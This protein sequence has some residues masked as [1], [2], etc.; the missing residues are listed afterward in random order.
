MV[1]VEI[2]QQQYIDTNVAVDKLQGIE[3]EMFFYS[4]QHQW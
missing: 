2:Y 1:Q 3:I 4:L